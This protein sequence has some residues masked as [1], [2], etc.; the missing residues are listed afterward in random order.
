ME[1]LGTRM[2]ALL[3]TAPLRSRRGKERTMRRTATIAGI[4]AALALPSVAAAGSSPKLVAQIEP[5]PNAHVVTT[6]VKRQIALRVSTARVKARAR[7]PELG[8]QQIPNA[9][10]TP[11][12]C[13]SAVVSIGQDE[14]SGLELYTW[15]TCGRYG[16]VKFG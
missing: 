14:R 7:I 11:T 16:G 15:S 4:A 3:A 8:D 1:M 12:L 5:Q 9:P 6:N 13:Q 2:A 10:K